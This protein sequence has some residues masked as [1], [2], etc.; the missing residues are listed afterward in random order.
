MFRRKTMLADAMAG[1]AVALVALP[2]S[3]AIAKCLGVK[4]EVGLITAIIGGMVVAVFGGFDCRF[5]VRPR[6]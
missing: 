2:L 1:I 3:L 6:R 5:P 4:P